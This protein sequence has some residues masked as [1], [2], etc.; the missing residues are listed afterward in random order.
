[1]P[2]RRTK[3]KKVTKSVGIVL[4]LL[5]MFVGWYVIAANYDYSALAGT[6][7]YRSGDVSSTLQLRANRTFHQEVVQ[8]GDRKEADGVWHRFGE[9]GVGFSIEFLR[10]P[11]AKT[12][13]EE[14]NKPSDD[15]VADAEFY[16]HFEKI[17]GVY[18][19]LKINANPP[20]PTLHKKLF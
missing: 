14:F 3:L 11:G 4:L 12:A 8:N 13:L 18:P 7:V 10:L 6:Y 20:G 15:P 19:T 9:G 17:L 2:E 16:G 1:V 5:G